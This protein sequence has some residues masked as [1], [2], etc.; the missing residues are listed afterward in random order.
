[1]SIRRWLAGAA[2][3]AAGA[4]LVGRATRPEVERPKWSLH[5]QTIGA[6]LNATKQVREG[7]G[8]AAGA[9]AEQGDA[10]MRHWLRLHD[11][12]GDLRDNERTAFAAYTMFEVV[13]Q[14]TR[15]ALQFSLAGLPPSY[16]LPVH[17]AVMGSLAGA[18]QRIAWYA[19]SHLGSDE[20]EP[21]SPSVPASA[22]PDIDNVAERPE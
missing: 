14:V 16:A 7:E 2:L 8:T 15:W 20:P 3:G 19:A 13:T 10:L 5:F 21:F 4:A 17:R 18:N 11:I 1:M 9:W 6:W 22:V 12:E